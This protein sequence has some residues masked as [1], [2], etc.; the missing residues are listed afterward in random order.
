MSVHREHEKYGVD[1]GV[2]SR[3][4]QPIVL[5]VIISVDISMLADIQYLILKPVLADMDN[6]LRIPNHNTV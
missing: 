2:S 6:M 5:S 3:E 1:L 4:Q